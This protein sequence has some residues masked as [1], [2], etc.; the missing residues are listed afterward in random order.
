MSSH[1]TF[2]RGAAILAA[3]GVVVRLMGAALRIVLASPVFLGDKGIGL[4]QMAYP[5]FSTL[6]TVSTAGIPVAISK[7]VAENLALSNYKQAFRVFRFALV[8]L[9]FSGLVITAAM[10]GGAGF[11]ARVI[12]KQP[13]AYYSL[14]A[15]SPAI[16]FVTVM[17]VFRGFFQGRQK[18][19]PTAIS[20]LVE[21]LGRVAASVYLVITL[22]PRGLEFAAAGASFGAVIGS[23]LGLTVLLFMFLGDRPK[24]KELELGSSSP[25]GEGFKKIVSQIF[26][27]A[28][29]I[30]L[31]SLIMQLFNLIDLAVVTRRLQAAG[32]SVERATALYG[33]LTGMAGS[34]IYFPNVVVIALGVSLVPAISEAL[35]RKSFK[36]ITGRTSLAVKITVLF[37]LPAAVGLYTL[38]TPIT[39]LL[40]TAEAVE[41][42]AP[43]AV[44]SWSVIALSLYITSTNIMQGLGRPAIPVLNMV[45]GGLVKGALCWML[46]ANPSWNVMGSAAASLIGLAVA[47]IA[48][49]YY[50]ARLT[51][52][53]F[54][55]PD[56]VLWPGISVVVMAAVVHVMYRGLFWLSRLLRFAP[57]AANGVAVLGAIAAGVAGYG[58]S[59]LL[60][61]GVNREDLSL[62]PR[63]GRP[64]IKFA[65]KYNLLRK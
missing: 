47:A 25:G 16:F 41:A 19:L 34:V 38:S 30:T 48:N 21:Q 4:Y 62:I 59:L 45:Y 24:Y 28:V 17:S 50:L 32:F 61:G 36:L 43:L 22:L 8:I 13:R 60:S 26:R 27:L 49:L 2:V 37:S 42:A 23:I 11:I 7:L 12:I 14:V 3:A 6:L 5:I 65:E 51:G 57:G 55:T 31:G 64:L 44:L 52:W 15:I 9:T 53:R 46:T 63:A 58:L 18:M 29:P 40:F 10:L 35:A 33:Q 54:R 56:L 39:V 1:S 20:Q